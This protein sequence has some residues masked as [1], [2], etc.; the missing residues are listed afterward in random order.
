MKHTRLVLAGALLLV[1]L[2]VGYLVLRNR[3]AP[4][5]PTDRDHGRFISADA[6]QACHGP[7]KL[8]PRGR[9]HP[10]GIDCLRCHGQPG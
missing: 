4:Q 2:L 9:N 8:Y 7:K 1:T 5:L 3:Q 10:I 6:C